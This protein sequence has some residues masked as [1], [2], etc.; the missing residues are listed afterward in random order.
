LGW[1]KCHA[2]HDLA[3]REGGIMK[4]GFIGLGKMGTRMASKL[5]KEGFEVHVWNRSSDPVKELKLKI[6]S[7]KLKV[8]D[9]IEE[10]V[11]S[12][13]K[14]RV[15]WIMVSHKAVDDVLSEV[16]KYVE[17]EDIVIDGGNSFYKD[18]Q[19]RYEEFDKNGIRYLGI[20]TSGGILAEK[21]G[22]PFMVGGS[23][24]GYETIK[25]IL[26]S[27]ARPSGGHEYFGEGGAG[28]FVKM[29]HNGIE[30]G[31][32]QSLSEGF[33][34]LEKSDYKFDL[35]KIA[36]LFQKGTIVS[37]FLLDRMKD[38]LDRGEYKDYDGEIEAS[39]EG[40]WTVNT[41]KEEGIDV[42]IIER[43]FEYRKRSKTEEKVKNSTTAKLV[44]ALRREFG[45]HPVRLTSAEERDKQDKEVKEK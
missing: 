32:M 18:T 15:I 24:S 16:K 36:G 38:A 20:G 6:K 9:S 1:G 5:L 14:P 2:E 7:E 22:Y 8:A 42:E 31:Q 11:K 34:V 29:V 26:D 19:R 44:S 4:I 21:N 25:P 17:K 10:L 30:Y 40:E 39:G 35:P 27:L 3:S 23:Q 45:G 43:S 28:H 13:D 12:L 41:A 37:G 33:E